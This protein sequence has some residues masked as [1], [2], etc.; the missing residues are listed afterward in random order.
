MYG[1]GKHSLWKSS[2]WAYLK[3]N[4]RKM[5][6]IIWMCWFQGEDD[7]FMVYELNRMC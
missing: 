1:I 7:K 3:N 6:D 2:F 5:N 4:K